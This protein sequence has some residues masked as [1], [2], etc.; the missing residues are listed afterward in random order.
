MSYFASYVL[1]YEDTPTNPQNVGY[2]NDLGATWVFQGTIPGTFPREAKDVYADTVRPGYVFAAGFCG[3]KYSTDFGVTWLN[4]G[5][6]YASADRKDRISSYDSTVFLAVGENIDKSSDGGLTFFP[7]VDGVNTLYPDYP[8]PYDTFARSVL[9]FNNSVYYVG[10]N[11]KLFRSSNGGTTWTALNGNIPI[12]SESSILSIISINTNDII[13]STRDGIYKSTNS[14]N[15]FTSILSFAD[16]AGNSHL[17]KISDTIIYCIYYAPSSIGDVVLYK[18]LDGGTTWITNSFGASGGSGYPADILCYNDTTAVTVSRSAGAYYTDDSGDTF[19]NPTLPVK[20]M[21]IS[22][23]IYPSYRLYNCDDE[24]ITIDTIQDLSEYTNPSQVVRLEEF[25]NTCWQVG[26]YDE[27]V[28]EFSVV[29][30]DGEPFATCADCIPVYYELTNCETE[31]IVYA[32][33]SAALLA[34]K[35][36]TVQILGEGGVSCYTVVQV[37]GFT[38]EILVPVTI[39]QGGFE[40][41]ICCLPAPAPEPIVYTRTIPKPYK[42]FYHITDSECD[43]KTNTTFAQNYYR[44]FQT[45][46][47]GIANSCPDVNFEKIWLKKELSDYDKINP[48]G[49]CVPPVVTTELVC[50]QATLVTCDTPTDVSGTGDFT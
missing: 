16:S 48:V 47:N 20:A 5:G 26:I 21:A 38:E 43:I 31:D 33:A 23:A 42:Q 10:I 9:V 24:T 45:I 13:V 44:L 14:G 19:S 17:Y 22:G 18:T 27:I 41:C 6:T 35:D 11:D 39:S 36:K 34:N 28:T 30:V 4:A 37:I 15:T 7:V 12:S 1:S 2:C 8:V 29:T 40:D 50:P 46:K 25:P 3:I 49:V 32:E